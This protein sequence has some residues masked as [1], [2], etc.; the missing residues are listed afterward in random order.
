MHLDKIRQQEPKEEDVVDRKAK[1]DPKL[2]RNQNR[3]TE[4]ERIWGSDKRQKRSR[5]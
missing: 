5:G 1:A 3:M 4:K 2:Q